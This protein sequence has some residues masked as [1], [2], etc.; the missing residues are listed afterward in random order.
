[1]PSGPFHRPWRTPAG[2]RSPRGLCRN[3]PASRPLARSNRDCCF[4]SRSLARRRP[5]PG[6]WL[7]PAGC[8]SRLGRR[9][10]PDFARSMS[11]PVRDPFF[12][13]APVTASFLIFAPVTEFFLSCLALT[14]FFGSLKA[15]K[16]VPTIPS[17]SAIRATIIAGEGIRGRAR[18]IRSLLARGRERGQL[19][20]RVRRKRRRDVRLRRVWPPGARGTTRVC[21]AD[22][23]RSSTSGRHPVSSR[24][25]VEST[26][27]RSISPSGLPSPW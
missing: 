22:R 13:F 16:P 21:G 25:L 1:M 6:G 11:S 5:R 14:L 19:S 3:R 17:T 18:F 7:W 4:R 10:G 2:G 9:H 24:S 20:P 8:C 27:W 26:N 23:P 12:T 15:A